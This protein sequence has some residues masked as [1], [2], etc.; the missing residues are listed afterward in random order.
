MLLVMSDASWGSIGDAA[1]CRQNQALQGTELKLRISLP[2]VEMAK[3]ETQ[4]DRMRRVIKDIVLAK[5]LILGWN[6]RLGGICNEAES[7]IEQ[8]R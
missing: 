2:I 3:R 8:Q 7:R 6:G 4:R 1:T 5:S